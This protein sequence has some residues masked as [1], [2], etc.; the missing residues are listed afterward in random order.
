M[1]HKIIKYLL[2]LL[3]IF[4]TSKL[5]A[6]QD[7]QFTHYMYNMS[8]MNPAYATDNP[9]VINLGGLYRAQWVGIKGAPTTQTFFAH[10]P[11]SKRVEVGISFVHDEIGDV[12][13]ENNIFA[14]FAYV[15][16]IGQSTKLSFG[17]KAGVTLFDTNFNGFVL[18]DPL[19]DPA[20]QNNISQVFPN[21]G[22]GMYL[23]GDNYYAGLSAPNLMTSRHIET[24][25]GKP[26]SGV[27]SV[28]FFLTGGYV[29]TFN[30]NDNIKLKPAFMA[31]G[32]EGAPLS[33]DVTTNILINNKFELGAGYRMGDSV[34]GLASFY[35][36]PQLRIGYSYDYTLTNLSAFNSGSHEFFL[37]YDLDLNK[38]SS[39]GKGYDKSPRFF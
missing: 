11:L 12:V 38:L 37:L 14:D 29:F 10:K 26:G 23:F 28:H 20:F 9:D 22:T 3:V 30:G 39:S 35:I 17:I 5:Q 33:L 34:S 2:V 8:V 13:K 36:T 19:P 4:L 21:I 7:P 6:Q 18:T 1:K 32:V 16:P 24:I 15:L 31:K 25:N 27:E